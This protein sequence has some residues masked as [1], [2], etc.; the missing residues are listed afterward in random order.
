[1]IR[2]IRR[3]VYEMVVP[4]AHLVVTRKARNVIR[5]HEEVEA[6]KY[7]YLDYKIILK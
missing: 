6:S 7:L 3:R 2:A 1:M 4:V 5:E